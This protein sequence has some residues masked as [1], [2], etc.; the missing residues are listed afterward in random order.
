VG[1][2]AVESPAIDDYFDGVPAA[3]GGFEVPV[4]VTIVIHDPAISPVVPV[5]P[6]VPVS[7]P[8]THN[9]GPWN[10]AVPSHHDWPA[11][12]MATIRDTPRGRRAD[13]DPT[14]DRESTENDLRGHLCIGPR[15]NQR[16]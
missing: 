4:I 10:P 16:G 5:I 8:T 9:D 2:A 7:L 3:A 1:S 15:R 13:G 11:D 12:G 6:V 14:N